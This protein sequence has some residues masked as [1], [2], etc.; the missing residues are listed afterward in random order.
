M[1]LGTYDIH[2]EATDE[3]PAFIYDCGPVTNDW[4]ECVTEDWN[5]VP[6]K[7]VF[8]LADSLDVP[9]II[10][11]RRRFHELAGLPTDKHLVYRKHSRR[12]WE[13]HYQ[14]SMSQTDPVNRNKFQ[15]DQWQGIVDEAHA[16]SQNPISIN[17]AYKVAKG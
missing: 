1:A 10:R 4:M 17:T 13:A 8:A 6:L 9:V 14:D 2:V 7:K 16:F 12:G 15:H 11:G 5:R 3:Y